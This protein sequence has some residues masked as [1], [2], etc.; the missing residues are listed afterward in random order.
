MGI[1]GMNKIYYGLFRKG[2]KCRENEEMEVDQ[3]RMIGN[4][5]EKR[6]WSCLK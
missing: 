5:G 3:R 2:S 6:G 1:V 4:L